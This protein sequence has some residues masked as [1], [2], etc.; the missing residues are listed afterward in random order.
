MEVA[1]LL[2]DRGAN[3]KAQDGDGLT[4]LHVA[5]GFNASPEMAELLL[6]W[7]ADLEAVTEAEKT[8]LMLAVEGYNLEVAELLLARGANAP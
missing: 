5:A 6:N 2:L 7:G 8:P 1:E 4:P 3:I